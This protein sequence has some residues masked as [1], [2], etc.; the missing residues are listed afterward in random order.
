VRVDL[1]PT[2]VDHLATS[3]SV[4]FSIAVTYF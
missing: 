2:A 3:A 1:E 4:L